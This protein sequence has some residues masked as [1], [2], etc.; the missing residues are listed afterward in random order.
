[1]LGSGGLPR[2]ACGCGLLRLPRGRSGLFCLSSGFSSLL[3]LPRSSSLFSL[4]RGCGGLLRLACSRGLLCLA[5]G[6]GGLLRLACSYGLL[7]LPRGFGSLLCLARGGLF[8]LACRFTFLVCGFARRR[9][10]LLRHGRLF[11][12]TSQCLLKHQLPRGRLLFLVAERSCGIKLSAL[13]CSRSKRRG[14]SLRRFRR[15]GS[16]HWSNIAVVIIEERASLLLHWRRQ[17]WR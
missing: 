16:F 8:R 17:V 15:V 2:L 4:K 3:R 5:R 7:R 11:F 6:C 10:H 13:M 1:M 14:H 12:S 9:C